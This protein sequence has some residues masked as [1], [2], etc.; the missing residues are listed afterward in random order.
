MPATNSWTRWQTADTKVVE[1]VFRDHGFPRV[2]AYRYDMGPI[3]VRILSRRF[4]GKGRWQRHDIAEKIIDTLP[5]NLRCG[6]L[7]LA[8]LTPSEAKDSSMNEEFEHPSPPLV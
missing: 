8:L 3:R 7:F 1:Q 2:D 6:I 4:E 5:E